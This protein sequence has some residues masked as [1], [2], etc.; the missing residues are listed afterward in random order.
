LSEAEVKRRKTAKELVDRSQKVYGAIYASLPEELRKQAEFIPQGFAYGLWHW[1][2]EKFQSTEADSVGALLTQWIALKQGEDE[3]FDAYRARVDKLFSLLEAAQEKQ[4][5]RMYSLL[6][7]DHLQPQYKQAV[8]ALKASGKMKDPEK[9]DWDEIAAF[10]NSHERAER[11]TGTENTRDAWANS[12]HLRGK[13]SAQ[14]RQGGGSD[15]KQREHRDNRRC[16]ICDSDEHLIADCPDRS[17]VV[18]GKSARAHDK[19][20]NDRSVRFAGSSSDK[21]SSNETASAAVRQRSNNRFRALSSDEDEDS[22]SETEQIYSAVVIAKERVMAAAKTSEKKSALTKEQKETIAKAKADKAK[23]EAEDKE[24]AKIAADREAEAIREAKQKI[25]AAAPKVPQTY[26]ELDKALSTT[27]WGWDTMAS[28]CV[29]GNRKCFGSLRRVPPLTI[30]TADGGEVTADQSGTIELRLT[31]MAGKPLRVRIENVHYNPKFAA[32]LLSNGI[33]TTKLGWTFHSDPDST[34]VET[35]GGHRVAVCRKGK[36]SVLLAAPPERVYSAASSAQQQQRDDGSTALVRLHERLGHMAYDKM[37]ALVR[38]GQVEGLGTHSKSALAAAR[39]RVLECRSCTLGKQA[40]TNFDHRGM[41]HGR[42]PAEILHMDM[43][44]IKAKDL[45]G[46][47][48]I[49]YGISMMD[50]FTRGVWHRATSSKDKIAAEVIDLLKLVEKQMSGEIKRIY[51]DGGSEFI[52]QTL[53]NYTRAQGIQVRVAPPHTP[54]LDGV[55]ERSIRTFKDSARTLLAHAGAPALFWRSAM[56]HSIWLWNRTHVAKTTKCTPYQQAMGRPAKISEKTVGVWGSDCFVHLRK[57]QRDGAMSAKSAP[58]IYLGH[59]DGAAAANVLLLHSM[60]R[61]VSRDVRF[62]NNSFRHMAALKGGEDA[63]AAL[64]EQLL[65]EQQQEP[66]SSSISGQRPDDAQ[67]KGE[68]KEEEADA[69]S[70]NESAVETEAADSEAEADPDEWKVQEIIARRVRSGVPE[71]RVRWE[72]FGADEDT[73]EP[74]SKVSELKAMDDFLAAHPQP[75]PRS[76]PRL[77]NN[78]GQRPD[79]EDEFS[80]HDGRVEMAMGAIR[81]MQTPGA[82]LSTADVEV[83][84]KAIATSIDSIGARTPTTLKQA[85]ASKDWPKWKAAREKEHDSCIQL[86]VWD[87]V[88]RSALPKGAKVL[89]LKEVYKIKQ[90]EDGNISSYKARFT[91]MGN[92]QRP[93]ID[94]KETFARTAMYKTE[95]VALSLAARFDYELVQF[96]VPTAFLNAPLEEEIYMEY[97]K[98]FGKDH[99]VCKL[100]K[101]SY[102]LRQA[103]HNFD[104]LI[105]AFIADTMGWTPTVSDPCFYYK[106]SRTGR[107]MLLYRF[108]DDLQAQYH[109]G[110]AA[111][112]AESSGKL[113]ERFNIKK[114]E[115]ATWMLGMRITRN[116]ATRTITLDQELYISKALERFGLA[117]CK[118]APSPEDPGAKNDTTSPKLDE[119]ADRQRFMEI[120]GTLM[121]AA[122]S[123]RPDISHAVHYLASNMVAPTARHMLAADRVLRYLAGSKAI[124]L[125]FGSHNGD[126][127]ADSRGH[128]TQVQI[129]VCAYADADWANDRTDRKSISGWVAKLNGDPVSWSSKKQRVVSLST[130][131]AELYAEAAAIQEVLWL[132]GIIAELGLNS[133]TGSKVYGDN[134]STIAVS[135]NGVKGERTKHVD[136]KYHFVTETVESGKVKLV[137]VPSAQQQADIFTKA[138]PKPTF[139]TLRKQ[140]MTA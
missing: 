81:S 79:D 55:A 123:S 70:D 39:V 121:Y 24:A 49:R 96:D 7:L 94:F 139:L 19:R 102:G 6:L 93:G 135:K 28:V 45:Q 86:D 64:E 26:A 8:L 124:G 30:K 21:T 18:K 87:E 74:E 133:S 92:F 138:L 27:A 91:P 32:N 108:V 132:R 1:L 53:L 43:Y 97:P 126:S 117:E 107:L 85:Q 61:V 63:V 134:Q 103:P 89:P 35:A 13:P 99:L 115:A 66:H 11:S 47:M 38:D 69:D 58:A 129:D 114:M 110:D 56:E 112:F 41:E 33:M 50:S 76:S 95:R 106:R 98:G 127:V 12:A 137:W 17:K 125:A 54:Q 37:A 44:V 29:T 52:N 136:V 60:K 77:R 23:R 84:M 25:D 111:E 130:C 67:R 109:K 119:P 62:L 78:S 14:Q 120:V 73:W 16:F 48:Q 10:I 20:R 100:K 105:S 2:E 65:G 5:R 75:A 82:G 122:I 101:S 68:M 128:G 15:T 9:A 88:E 131:E 46:V 104:K 140:L 42:A 36:I 51:T 22:G 57:D 113:T 59:S 72:G 31:S 40:R 118:V 34:Y 116:R 83:V 4:S 3:S 80:E 71:F 90:D